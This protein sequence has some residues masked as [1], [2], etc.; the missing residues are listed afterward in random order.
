VHCATVHYSNIPPYASSRLHSP[1]HCEHVP[2]LFSSRSIV[3]TSQAYLSLLCR[4]TP[5]FLTFSLLFDRCGTDN[6]HLPYH[7]SHVY[8]F[9]TIR[10]NRNLGILSVFISNPGWF[11][12]HLNVIKGLINVMELLKVMKF[13]CTSVEVHIFFGC[14]RCDYAHLFDLNVQLLHL[15][16][17]YKVGD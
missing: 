12:L 1:S 10:Y 14:V 17:C 15:H 7:S 11:F 2:S 4:E 16:N 13:G 3:P 8:Y 6:M 5:T 9:S